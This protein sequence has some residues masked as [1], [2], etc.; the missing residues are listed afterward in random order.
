MDCCLD[1]PTSD[2]GALVEV[3]ESAGLVG[4]ALEDVVTEAVHDRHRLA[5]D[6]GVGVDLAERLV[7]AYSRKYHAS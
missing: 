5:A 4:N 6:A 1:L 2:G 7:D 3:P